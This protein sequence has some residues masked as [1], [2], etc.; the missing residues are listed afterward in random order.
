MTGK[1]CHVLLTA[2]CLLLARIPVALAGHE[3]MAD[4]VAAHGAAVESAHG[5]TEAAHGEGGAGL[6]QFDPSSFASQVFWLAIAFAVLYIFFA[7]KALPA[8]GDVL[9]KRE[10]HI[11]STLVSAKHQKETAEKLQAEYERDLESARQEA[12]GAFSDIE[13]LIKQKSE[14]K[15]R[16]FHEGAVIRIEKT[17]E[18]IEKAKSAA[19]DDMQS[20]AA[21]IASQ[22]AEKIIGVETDINQAKTV[23]RSLKAKAA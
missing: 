7:R 13:Q 10:G 2:S 23:V 6:P 14:A 5:A 9:Q 16:A 8:L 21:E 22:A 18:E 17:E 4:P 15:N 19:M 20:L 12:T 3:E 11:R 1:A